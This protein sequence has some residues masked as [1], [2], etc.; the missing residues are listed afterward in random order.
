[1]K[2]LFCIMLA[3]CLFC[4]Y[5]IY[6]YCDASEQEQQEIIQVKQVT[7]KPATQHVGTIKVKA[8][9][10]I[11]SEKQAKFYKTQ[12]KIKEIDNNTE[13]VELPETISDVFSD[14]EIYLICRVVETE[15][16]QQDFDSKVNVA[17]V[18]LNRYYDGRF[19]ETITEVITS[20]KQF[21]YGRKN[22]EEDTMLAVQYAYECEDTTQGSLYFHSNPKTDTFSGANFVFQD[23]AGH[24]FY[25][26]NVYK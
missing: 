23:K 18:V 8:E 21:A 1:M 9:E 4:F 22:I 16:Y 3:V 14:E 13:C 19:G 15:C 25:K 20:P 6:I 2:K 5:S 11:K 10:D 24:N 26:P 12:D 7:N 17:N